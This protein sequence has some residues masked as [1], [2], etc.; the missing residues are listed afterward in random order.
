MMNNGYLQLQ[1]MHL[2]QMQAQHAAGHLIGP[3]AAGG[4]VGVA[5]SPAGM[6]HV[7]QQQASWLSPRIQVRLQLLQS[8]QTAPRARLSKHPTCEE[9][10]QHM[11]KQISQQ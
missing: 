9:T 2:Q 11:V 7:I 6:Q 4:Q 10:H 1:Q 3:Q 5:T 8:L